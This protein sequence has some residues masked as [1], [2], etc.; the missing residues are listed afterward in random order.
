MLLVALVDYCRCL[1][2]ACPYLLSEVFGHWS[3]LA[4]LLVKLLQLVESADNVWLVG[5]FLGGFA[6]A[7]LYL[8]VLLEVVFACFDVQFQQVVELLHIELVVAPQLVGLVS[9]HS[10]DFLPLLLQSLEVG[11]RLASFLGR[12][13]HGLYLLDYSELLLK[14]FL[15]FL[16]L[17]EESLLAFFLYY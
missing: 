2:E 9:R 10:L 13:S 16:F 14:V 5:K 6:Q 8:E 12:G 17:F 1:L 15:L 11:V 4:V 7:C 3:G